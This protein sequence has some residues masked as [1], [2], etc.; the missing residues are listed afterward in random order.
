MPKDRAP[1]NNIE[2][3]LRYDPDTG[4]FFWKMFASRMAPGDK[5]GTRGNDGYMVV[6]INGRNCGLHRLAF[7]IMG[8]DISG[9]EV[10][11]INGIK[12][13]NRWENLRAVSH[14]E[15][16]RNMRKSLRN[17][18][19]VT[20]VCWR[21]AQKKWQ[22]YIYIGKRFI[23]L[24]KHPG[25]FEAVASRKSAEITLGYHENHGK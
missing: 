9:M 14:A 22:A 4:E 20:G 24:G 21:A 6:I 11:H 12:H 7:A 5:A 1:P 10:D 3:L 25:L 17:T 16:M 19:G 13:D 8:I 2:D 15:N 18:S 23:H